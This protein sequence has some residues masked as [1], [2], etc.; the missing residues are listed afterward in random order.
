MQE[1]KIKTFC[2]HCKIDTN[3]FIVLDE[4]EA[5]TREIF[6]ESLGGD[7][8]W[9]VEL[10]QWI[11]TRCAGCDFLNMKIITT[12]VGNK[13]KRE[14]HFPRKV[15]KIPPSW[16]FGLD[17]DYVHL[18]SEI[19][20][21]YN[22][23]LLYLTAMGIRTLLDVY[24]V[25]KIGDVGTF[26]NKL[27]NLVKNGFITETQ[28][29]ILGITIDAGSASVHRLFK[30]ERESLEELIDVIENF[31]RI[32]ILERKTKIIEK[33]TPKRIVSKKRKPLKN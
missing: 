24:F 10:N 23:D 7:P 17:R 20:S 2:G 12:H 3:Q 32:E 21:A 5:D 1:K 28:K 14:T 19:Y 22:N 8:R 4:T 27:D 31:L 13:H 9:V 6:F 30:H 18:L 33:K 29:E 15:N 25:K 16:I 11:I 26:E